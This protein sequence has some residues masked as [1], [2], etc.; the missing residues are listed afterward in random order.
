MRILIIS[1]THIPVLAQKFPQ[2]IIEEAKNS[3]VCIHAGDFIEYNVFEK[4]YN[5][6]K[7]YGVYGNMDSREIKQKL[8][9]KQTIDIEGI[10]IGLIHGDGPPNKL[11]FFINKAFAKEFDTINIF[12]FGHSHCPCDKTIENRIY[13][14]PGSPTDKVFSSYNSYGI[15]EIDNKKIERKLIKI[16]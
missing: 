12:I 1:D 2:K 8:P 9:F 3:D 10:R 13:F 5:I 16:E 15:L 11:I 4:L 7:I 14:N 6:T